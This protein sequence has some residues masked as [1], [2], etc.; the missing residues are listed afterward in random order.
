MFRSS[1]DP[2]FGSVGGAIVQE[3]E[4]KLQVVRHESVIVAR[5]QFVEVNHSVKQRGQDFF[6]SGAVDD[7]LHLGVRVALDKDARPG[8]PALDKAERLG[9]RAAM[10]SEFVSV[11]GRNWVHISKDWRARATG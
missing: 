9:G 8:G 10:V 5:Q 2:A 3:C 4:R 11:T 7:G 6:S 1:L